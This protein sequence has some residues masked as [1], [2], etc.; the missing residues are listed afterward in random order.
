MKKV[1]LGK[2]ELSVTKTSFGALPIQRIPKED[3]AAILRR[4]YE[5]GINFFDTANAY[6][7]SEE[8]IGYAL[9]DVRNEIILATKTALLSVDEMKRNLE[10]SLKMLQTDY[11]D[12]LQLHNPSVVPDCDSEAYRFLLDAKRQGMIRHIGMTN[13]RL[14]RAHEALNSGLYETL[15]FPFSVLATEKDLELVEACKKADVGFI[16]MKAM[17][18]GLIRYPE[19]TF[20]FLQQY[21]NVVPIYGVQR[22]EELEQWLSIDANPPVYDDKMRQMIEKERVEL[23]GDFCRG[24]GYCMPCPAG[25]EIPT[26]GRISFLMGRSPYKTFLSKE[27]RE[28]MNK[29]ENCLN[30]GH[31]KAHCPFELDTPELLKREL[32]RYNAFYA[33]HM[34]EAER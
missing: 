6:T 3:A 12:L 2:S 22:M 29:I 10:N 33:E 15:Q 30:C 7:D 14:D 9:H 1:R 26:A 28:N 23:S 34:N 32:K 4:A 27:W 18:G 5:A 17:S 25:I 13:H 24:C 8:K 21:D 20:T 11:I 19:A 16:A 31:C